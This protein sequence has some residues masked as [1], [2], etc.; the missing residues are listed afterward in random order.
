MTKIRHK[1]VKVIFE[2]EN[3]WALNALCFQARQINSGFFQKNDLLI[4]PSKVLSQKSIFF[5]DLPYTKKFWRLV[6]SVS[7]G[8]KKGRLGIANLYPKELLNEAGKISEGFALLSKPQNKTVEILN[9]VISSLE[10]HYLFQKELDSLEKIIILPTTFGSGSSFSFR[11][12]GKK[13]EIVITLRDDFPP[14]EAGRSLIK[15]LLLLT[16]DKFKGPNLEKREIVT[17]FIIDSFFPY[18]TNNV[19]ISIDKKLKSLS[20]KYLAKL[21]FSKKNP[22]YEKGGEIY[23]NGKI[24]NKYL[25]KQE[26]ILTQLVLQKSPEIV[27]YDEI[28]Q[29]IWKEEV[30]QKFSLWAITK[31]KQKLSK[32]V[33]KFGAKDVIKTVRNEGYALSA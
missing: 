10:K 1:R 17:E 16:S 3:I 14:E 11:E 4:L 13:K 9:N 8:K 25:S 20:E 27:T 30:E 21:G 7:L 2:K 5:P 33:E 26:I 29:A 31:L 6:K 12:N 24:A 32:K 28:A 22:L 23:I 15:T 19:S 18:L